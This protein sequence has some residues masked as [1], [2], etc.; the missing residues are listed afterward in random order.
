MPPLADKDIQDLYAFKDDIEIGVQCL[1]GK[2]ADLFHDY[3]LAAFDWDHARGLLSKKD[4]D[5][6]D[7]EA[8]RRREEALARSRMAF[9]GKA[10]VLA[11]GFVEQL[12]E[13]LRKAR[14]GVTTLR[15]IMKGW[16]R[17]HG[18]EWPFHEGEGAFLAGLEYCA[19]GIE[20]A[21]D[22]VSERIDDAIEAREA[23]SDQRDRLLARIYEA[24]TR[25][26]E[27]CTRSGTLLAG[28]ERDAANAEVSK[29]EERLEELEALV[30]N[31]PRSHDDI[32]VRA[33]LARYFEDGDDG[34]MKSLD[35]GDVFQR[36][37]ARLIE[38]VLQWHGLDPTRIV[39]PP[40]RPGA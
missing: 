18:L 23:A 31:P 25:Q 21:V 15:A 5:G 17:Q 4:L 14:H 11:D 24:V 33:V 39:N 10:P 13:M 36:R 20:A 22:L 28:P 26:G 38:A 6:V 37:A 1:S 3:R 34:R 16:E 8:G 19:D 32:L 2:L 30:P 35:D 40:G 12:E 29:W 9:A 27:A 7:P